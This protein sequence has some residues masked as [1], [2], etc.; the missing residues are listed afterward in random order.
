VTR[1]KATEKLKLTTRN[2]NKMWIN[3]K[4]KKERKKEREREKKKSHELKF[5][6]ATDNTQKS[7]THVFKFLTP[8]TPPVE[9]TVNLHGF[10]SK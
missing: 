4:R 7:K 10:P 1:K 8:L 3:P 2:K 5:D 9:R 6:Q